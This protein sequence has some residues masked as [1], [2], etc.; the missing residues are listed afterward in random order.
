MNWVD[1]FIAVVLVITVAIGYKNGLFRSITTFA[2]LIIAAVFSINHADWLAIQVEGMFNISPSLRYIFC[3][4]IFF[5][6][7]LF[8]FKFVGYYFYKLVKLTAVKYPDRIGGGIFGLFK[9]VIIL[10]MVFIMFIFFPAF[11]KF[12]KGIDE[13][14]LAPHIRQVLPM[15][16]KL[17]EPFHPESGPFIAKVKSGILGSEAEKYAKNPESL[18][19]K[20]KVLGY[21]VKDQSVI[22][23]IDKYFSESIELAKKEAKKLK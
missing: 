12:N 16:F 6:G 4:L 20:Q 2:G 23:N 9:G 7:A 19:D 22:N 3:F 18:I 14:V 10:S 21:S 11:H 17:T 1:F 8:I 13:S 5:F 15:T